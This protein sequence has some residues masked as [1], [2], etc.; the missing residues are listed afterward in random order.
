[1]GLICIR[2]MRYGDLDEVSE[3]ESSIFPTPW[4]RRVF[5]IEKEK[6]SGIYIVASGD[7]CLMGYA[8]IMR[9]ADEGHIAN[10]AVKEQFRGSGLSLLLMH[11]LIIIAIDFGIDYLTLEVRESNRK[12]IRIY[13]LFG[14]EAVGLRKNYYP[15]SRENALVMW[16][17]R[18]NQK[19]YASVMRGAVKVIERKG[20][21]RRIEEDR[22]I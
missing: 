1:M 16:T 21:R 3:I 20:W 7:S 4:S 8:G 18:I 10:L 11:E 13:E 22:Y 9:F 6:E 5:L 14:F 15:M 12:A 19:S 2:Q 17:D